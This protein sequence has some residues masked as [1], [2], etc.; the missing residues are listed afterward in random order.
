MRAWRNPKCYTSGFSTGTHISVVLLST[1]LFTRIRRLRM[2]EA[3]GV[4]VKC[5]T[6]SRL[7]HAKAFETLSV[8]WSLSGRG[9]AV[10][11]YP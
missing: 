6:R 8:S 4:W 7:V 10:A 5:T 11:Y 3:K 1:P 2:G 9:E